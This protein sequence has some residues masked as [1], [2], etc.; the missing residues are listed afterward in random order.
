MS[1]IIMYGFWRSLAA[2]RV[3]IAL[4]LKGV[5]HREIPVDILNGAQ[6]SADYDRI[7]AE[8]VL[9]TLVDGET[10]LF[11]SLPMLEYLDERFPEPALL[12]DGAADRAYARALA[13][14]TVADSHPLVVPRVRKHLAASFGADAE[15]I[16]GWARH[17]MTEGLA[18]FE[19]LFARRPPSPYAVG[20]HPTVA[21]I[22]FASHMA[23]SRFFKAP[24]DAFPLCR[25]LSDRLD[26]IPAFAAAHPLKQP[27]APTL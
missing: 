8:H 12:P 1:T 20:A 17:W 14:V 25:A 2:Y 16:D 24:L 19:K 18:T 11:Q 13:L 27:G 5:D 26:A 6:H 21:D 23:G 4:N 7:N 22:C 10:T 3:R 9:P 15:A